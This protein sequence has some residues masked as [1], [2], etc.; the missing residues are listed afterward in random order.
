M[1]S[2]THSSA[3]RLAY[4]YPPAA[5]ATPAVPVIAS[6]ETFTE[7]KYDIGRQEIVFPET[8]SICPVHTGDWVAMILTGK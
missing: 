2:V 6:T 4:A 3:N 1:A 8:V 7:V 5:P